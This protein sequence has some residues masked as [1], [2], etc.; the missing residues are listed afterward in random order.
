MHTDTSLEFISHRSRGCTH[1][2][3]SWDT[4]SHVTI[5][6]SRSTSKFRFPPPLPPSSCMRP[7]MSM[8]TVALSTRHDYATKLYGIISTSPSKWYRV[9]LLAEIHGVTSCFSRA[10]AT[11]SVIGM[12]EE[13]KRFLFPS[14][15]TISRVLIYH[16]T[17]TSLEQLGL[18]AK[19]L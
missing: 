10:K 17:M 16:V 7:S 6:L 15:D 4:R 8:F 1:C 14:R 9:K 5:L 3:L 18:E 2:S 11:C 13:E 19:A 12:K